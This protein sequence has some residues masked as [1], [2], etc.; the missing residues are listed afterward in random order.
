M[1]YTD[2]K[3]R[4]VRDLEG[5]IFDSNHVSR[6]FFRAWLDGSYLGED[7]YRANR[8]YL[9]GQLMEHGLGIKLETAIRGWVI[10]EY[11]RFT[12]HDADCSVGYAKTIVAQHIRSLPNPLG[13][14]LLATYT[15]L[16]ISDALDLIDDEIKEHLK[17]VAA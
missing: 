13:A 4:I 16:L 14:D 7:H 10:H 8:A 9:R 11:A 2:K 1:G 17:G 15:D 6:R 5:D 3:T 12:A